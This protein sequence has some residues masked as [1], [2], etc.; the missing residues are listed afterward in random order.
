MSSNI[1]YGTPKMRG[2]ALVYRPGSPLPEVTEF[3]ESPEMEFLR[4]CVQGWLELVPS[5]DS[6]E[7]GDKVR[8]CV[9]F[10]NEE[11]KLDRLAFN[12][13]ATLLWDRAMRRALDDDSRPLYPNGLRAPNGGLAD[14]LV[15]PVLVLVGDQQFI[16]SL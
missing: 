2:T 16:D 13:H 4:A 8:R 7:Y 15:G 11:G 10:C 6:I 3:T 12:Q 14:V 5:F 1:F 9:V